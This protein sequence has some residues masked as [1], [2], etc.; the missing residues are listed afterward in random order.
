MYYYHNK[1]PHAPTLLSMCSLWVDIMKSSQMIQSVSWAK[2][3]RFVGTSFDATL[4][5]IAS[6]IAAM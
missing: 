6:G 2:T 5:A 1:H 4:E 3:N